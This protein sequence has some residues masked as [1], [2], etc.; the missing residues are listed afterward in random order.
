[1]LCRN[2][3]AWAFGACAKLS[4]PSNH[5]RLTQSDPSTTRNRR[6]RMDGS[7]GSEQIISLLLHARLGTCRS[8]SELTASAERIAGAQGG[9][10]AALRRPKPPLEHDPEKW[11]PVFGKDHAPARS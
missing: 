6:F 9:S 3:N 8:S 5:T 2:A 10:S 11:V 1:M 7:C 4:A